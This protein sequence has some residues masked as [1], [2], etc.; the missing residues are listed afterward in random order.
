MDETKDND[1]LML[2]DLEAD[3]AEHIGIA[4]LIP[5]SSQPVGGILSSL[6]PYPAL[7]RKRGGGNTKVG[8]FMGW[9]HAQTNQVYPETMAGG[10]DDYAAFDQK[11]MN[12]NVGTG[13]EEES[14]VFDLS[15]LPN[16]YN[17]A[18]NGALRFAERLEA[19]KLTIWR[20]LVI[21][22][23]SLA[24]TMFNMLVASVLLSY[25]YG[26]TYNSFT[27]PSQTSIYDTLSVKDNGQ[28]TISSSNNVPLQVQREGEGNMSLN[29]ISSE[30][31]EQSIHFG[32]YSYDAREGSLN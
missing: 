7:E 29:M 11:D 30:T 4:S 20:L 24:L 8:A 18:L 14:I 9:G 25:F 23:Y 15:S 3:S 17:D 16:R 28:T 21:I 27:S 22:S 1:E 32:W 5:V 13:L 12:A 10:E 2:V 19:L 6:T 31:S 26:L